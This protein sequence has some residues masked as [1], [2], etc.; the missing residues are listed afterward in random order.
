VSEYEV[1]YEEGPESWGAYSPD[2]PGC[3][4]VGDSR[5]EVEKLMREAIEFHIE[6]LRLEGFPV[7]APGSGGKVAA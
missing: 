4:T 1:I 6:G 3:I 5:A 2:S 7:P